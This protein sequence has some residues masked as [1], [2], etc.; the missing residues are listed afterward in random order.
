VLYARCSIRF[1]FKRKT[2]R[3]SNKTVIVRVY[4]TLFPTDDITCLHFRQS[5]LTRFEMPVVRTPDGI[6]GASGIATSSRMSRVFTTYWRASPR[7]NTCRFVV[8]NLTVRRRCL[9]VNDN[10]NGNNNIDGKIE[11]S[12][13]VGRP[14]YVNH[15]TRARPACIN[16][17]PCLKSFTPYVSICSRTT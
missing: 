16:T 11:I 15:K 6:K 8:V 3:Y 13:H 7:V 1:T 4:N 14:E 5:N 17:N 12:F 9:G 2:F 10:N